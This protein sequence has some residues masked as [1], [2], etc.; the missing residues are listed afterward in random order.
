MDTPRYVLISK[1]EPNGRLHGLRPVPAETPSF[2]DRSDPGSYMHIPI[3]RTHGVSVTVVGI[4]DRKT[5]A[6]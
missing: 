4:M 3:G 2:K 1:R 6:N 5:Y